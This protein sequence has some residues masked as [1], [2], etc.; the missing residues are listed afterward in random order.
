[1]MERLSAAV[2]HR[3]IG[4]GPQA[5]ARWSELSS[6]LEA[7]REQALGLN[8]DKADALAAAAADLN[9]TRAAC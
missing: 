2:R 5:A 9:R 3:A 1:L 4:S 6:R 7:L 8:L